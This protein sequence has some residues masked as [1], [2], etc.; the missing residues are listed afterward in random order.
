[1]LCFNLIS[2]LQYGFENMPAEQHQKQKQKQ[3]TK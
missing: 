3:I 2:N 1:M